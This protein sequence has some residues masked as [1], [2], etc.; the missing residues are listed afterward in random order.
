MLDHTLTV[1]LNVYLVKWFINVLQL[2]KGLSNQVPEN[3][4][5]YK[6]NLCTNMKPI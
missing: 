3:R 4:C 6:R 5:S 2:L 1:V